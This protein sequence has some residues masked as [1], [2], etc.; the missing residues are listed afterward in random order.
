[1]ANGV[2]HFS[3]PGGIVYSPASAHSREMAKWERHP[4]PDGSVTQQMIDAARREGVHH[5]AFEYQEFPKAM[6]LAKQTPNGIK[7]IEQVRAESSVEETNLKSRGF[8]HRQE[9][10]I[11]EVEGQNQEAAVFA[12]NREFHDRRMTAKAREEAEAI[13]SSTARHLGEIP[14]APIKKRGRPAKVAVTQEG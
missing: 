12:A 1:M 13:D 14:A 11:A 2:E 5:G 4:R 8:R 10:A 9:D 7:I 3:G 6:Y